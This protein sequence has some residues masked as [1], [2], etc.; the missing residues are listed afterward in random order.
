M[1]VYDNSRHIFSHLDSRKGL[2]TKTLQVRR[3]IQF[4]ESNCTQ[5]QWKSGDTLSNLALDYYNEC[6][7][8]WVILEANK[9]YTTEFDIQVGDILNIPD[10][11]E[12]VTLLNV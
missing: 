5:Y 10:Y 3:R 7:L 12:V 8:R 11:S 4:N 9:Q 6:K 1:S 2:G